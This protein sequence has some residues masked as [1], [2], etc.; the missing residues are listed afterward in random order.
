MKQ[1][2]LK[3]FGVFLLS[4]IF[5]IKVTYADMNDPLQSRI[6]PGIVAKIF[7]QAE[8][9]GSPQGNPPYIPVLG[10]AEKTTIDEKI[11]AK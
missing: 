1:L 4:L 2:L 5:L 11:L 10:T 9:L 3:I 8:A 6:N 7:P